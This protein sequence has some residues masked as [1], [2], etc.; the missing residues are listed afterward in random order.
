[1][2]ARRGVAVPVPARGRRGRTR[3]WPRSRSPRCWGPPRAGARRSPP[4]RSSRAS[5]TPSMQGSFVLLPFGVPDR[6]HRG[7]REVLLGPAD[8]PVRAPHARPRA[9]TRRATTPGELYGPEAVPRLGRLEPPGRDRLQ[10]GLQERGRVR[11]KP[12]H[13]RAGQDHARLHPRADQARAS[14]R[15]SWA[16]RRSSRRRWRRRRQG[17]LARRD[18][19]VERPGLRRRALP[20][21]A[22]RHDARPSPARGWY[23]GDFHVHAEHSA[24]GDATMT[25]TF[26]FAFKPLSQGGAGLDFITLSDYVVPTRVGRDRPLPARLPRAS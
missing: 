9:S 26:G 4:P 22:L 7:A 13:E 23:A 10:R 21:R 24:L 15:S 2:R 5:S 8:R 19:A 3:R 11:R 14:G 16:W 12:A 17:R 1:M 18:P 20:A 6:H 25:E